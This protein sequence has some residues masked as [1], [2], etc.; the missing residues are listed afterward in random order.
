[1]ARFKW[2]NREFEQVESPLFAEIFWVEKQTKTDW[3]DMTS[4]ER[5]LGV[6]LLSL[7]RGGVMLQWADTAEWTVGDFEAVEEEEVPTTPGDEAGS[8]E[9]STP[10][11]TSGGSTSQKSSGSRRTTSTA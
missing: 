10:S 7:R 6:L 1:M 3:D 2:D 5:K 8:D 11:A 9:T 4:S